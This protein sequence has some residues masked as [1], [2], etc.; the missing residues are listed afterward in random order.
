MAVIDYKYQ[1]TV[2]NRNNR[3]SI[4]IVVAMWLNV[5]LYVNVNYDN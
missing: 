3:V 5:D 2:F 1:L 4:A